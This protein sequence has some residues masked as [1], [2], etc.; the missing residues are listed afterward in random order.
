VRERDRVRDGAT[1]ANAVVLRR[2]AACGKRAEKE[3]PSESCARGMGLGNQRQTVLYIPC[4]RF[5]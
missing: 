4:T 2:Y 3:K 1:D 5:E